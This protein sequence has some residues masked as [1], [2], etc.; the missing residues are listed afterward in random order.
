MN[1]LALLLLGACTTPPTIDGKVVDI[2]GEPI[3]GATVLM[4]GQGE[5]PLTDHEGRYSFSVKPGE[6]EIKAGKEGYIQAHTTLDVAAEGDAPAGPVFELYK[7]PEVA[8]FLTKGPGTL[9]DPFL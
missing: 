5:R 1:L 4:V 6:H 2:W 7:K 8:G 3:E 9:A